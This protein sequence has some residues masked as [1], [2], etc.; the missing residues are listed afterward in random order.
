M[1]SQKYPIRMCSACRERKLKKDLMRISKLKNDN[2]YEIIY[3]E[4][5]KINARGAYICKKES[6][7]KKARK[8]RSFERAFSCAINDSLYSQLEKEIAKHE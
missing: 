8:I 7:L 6:C 2:G 4:T 3:D 5:G 1:K